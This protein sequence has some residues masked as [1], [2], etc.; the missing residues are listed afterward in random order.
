MQAIVGIPCDLKQIGP[1]PFHAVGDKYIAAVAGGVGA[2]PV[3]LPSLGESGLRDVLG[4]LD[5][6]L[7]PGSLSNVAPQHYGGGPSRPGCLLDPMRDATTLPLIRLAL[8]QGIPLLGICRGL[9]EINVA[10]EGE[11]YQYVQEEDGKFDHREPQT[12]D[13][14]M[15]YAVSHSV[16]FAEGSLLRQWTGKKSA[17]VNSLHQQG[18]KRL[19]ER[20]IC[21][22]L[23]EDGLVEAFRVRDSKG[24]AFAVQWHPEWEYWSNPLSMTILKAFGDACR[25]RR[26]Q[27]ESGSN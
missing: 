5:G 10:M 3:L 22:A 20:L 1:L 13:L 19:S 6:V 11:L 4:L 8:E 26:N 9:H 15:M 14:S 18:V 27:R 7:L 12:L 23:A 21:E 25:Q 16:L 2:V 17:M 24:F